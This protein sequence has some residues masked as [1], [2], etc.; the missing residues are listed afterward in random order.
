MRVAGV[1]STLTAFPSNVIIKKGEDVHMQCATNET[2]GGRPNIHWTHDG[3]PVVNAPCNVGA[4]YNTRFTSEAVNDTCAI[5]GL[6][7]SAMGNGNQ[8]PY[9]CY[10]DTGIVAQ[11]VA[12]LIRMQFSC[13]DSL[14]V[15]SA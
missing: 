10:D 6:G 8:G 7:S 9:N 2:S 4:A 11:A 3:R 14:V 15:Q 12:V 1:L 5:K 13:F